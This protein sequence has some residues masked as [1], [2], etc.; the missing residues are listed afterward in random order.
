MDRY[1]LFIGLEISVLLR[2]SFPSKLSIDSLQWQSE[3][4]QASVCVCRSWQ[5]ILKFNGMKKT[6]NNPNKSETEKEL[7]DL[8]YLIL[9]CIIKW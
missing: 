8:K 2:C 5:V 4:Q 3:S 1:D 7:E 9:K 6:F